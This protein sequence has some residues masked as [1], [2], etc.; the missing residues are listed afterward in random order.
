MPEEA[1]SLDSFAQFSLVNNEP[2]TF[3][4]P[5]TGEVLSQCFMVTEPVAVNYIDE[6]R[7]SL[8]LTVAEVA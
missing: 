3:H 1:V 6:Q 4:D 2:F 5:V 8:S 7:A